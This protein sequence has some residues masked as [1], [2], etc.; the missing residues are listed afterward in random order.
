[1]GEPGSFGEFRYGNY[2][3]GKNTDSG[4]E[5]VIMTIKTNTVDIYHKTKMV[6]QSGEYWVESKAFGLPRR[7]TGAFNRIRAGTDEA[8]RLEH[9]RYACSK[10][11]ANGMKRC[12]VMKED[13]C[14]GSGADLANATYRAKYISFDNIRLSGGVG[15]V[16]AGA[17]CKDDASCVE[18]I[19][20]QCENVEHGRFQGEAQ[21]CAETFCCPYPFTDTDQDKDVDSDDFAVL[22][23]CVTTGAPLTKFSSECRCLDRNG[24]HQIDTTDVAAFVECST[25][26][27]IVMEPGL[28]ACAP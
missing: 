23:R 16:Q 5:L 3:I 25:G 27:G 12:K 10:D 22:Q 24:D 17:C 28:P 26:P 8:C 18:V 4:Y 11:Y 14:S 7:Y 9:D 20:T 1:M 21:S 6:D 2:K 13:L 19:K 15:G